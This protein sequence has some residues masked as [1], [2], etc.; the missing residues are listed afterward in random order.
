MACWL[1]AGDLFFWMFNLYFDFFFLNSS[2]SLDF[3]CAML[4][5]LM[6]LLMCV[7]VREREQILESRLHEHFMQGR[8]HFVPRQHAWCQRVTMAAAVRG[9]WSWQIFS[10]TTRVFFRVAASRRVFPFTFSLEQT[11]SA[12]AKAAKYENCNSSSDITPQ[13]ARADWLM[14]P[15]LG[16]L[17]CRSVYFAHRRP[18]SNMK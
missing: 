2:L 11:A 16:N 18:C 17:H 14:K 13:L 6:H 1:T 7:Q 8:Y 3:K 15:V 12:A 10:T 4:L 9:L 5:S